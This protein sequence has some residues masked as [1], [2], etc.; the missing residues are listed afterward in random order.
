MDEV[1]FDNR[2]L[3]HKQNPLLLKL[4]EKWM[5]FSTYFCF[6]L[7]AVQIMNT[8]W[9]ESKKK[10]MIINDND[11][12]RGRAIACIVS[13]TWELVTKKRKFVQIWEYLFY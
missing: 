4:M 13:I 1:S 8:V 12:P 6:Y 5:L 7:L 10:N 9:R 3:E 2:V 11:A